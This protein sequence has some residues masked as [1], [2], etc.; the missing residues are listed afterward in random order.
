MTKT[1]QDNKQLLIRYARIIIAL[2]SILTVIVASYVLIE[3]KSVIVP[4]AIA[5]IFSFILKPLIEYLE[6]KHIPELLSILL[7][8]FI[9]FLIIYALG[10]LVNLNIRS[11]LAN[12]NQY[13]AK[14]DRFT[15][16]L[17]D[18]IN[19]AEDSS[20]ETVKNNRYQAITSIIQSSSIKSIVT[21][22]FG[23]ISVILSDT[24]LVLLYLL[25][26]LLGRNRLVQKLDIAFKRDTALVLKDLV[27]TVTSQINKYV[28]TKTW[29]SAVTAAL[30]SLILWLFGVEF[31]LIWG[32]LTFLLNFIPNIGSIFA[33][34]FPVIFSIIQFDSWITIIWI[35]LSLITVQFIIGNVLEPR[36]VGK[37]MGISPVVVLFSLMF[38]G[39]TWGII[40]MILAVPSAV[41]VK[42]IMDN[43]DTL[44]PF[45]VLISD[46]K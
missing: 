41:L 7:V 4:F 22:I 46:H 38:W 44:K 34:L 23:S 42:I 36:I 21:S 25:F 9:T 12:V 31:A 1:D 13:E 17:S 16:Q 8:I 27:N 32:M 39:F 30:V 28:V 15:E 29:I 45:G 14:Y 40:G 37:S 6:K 2:L 24:F 11:F 19:L 20:G 35:T 26:L 3:L 5:L 10:Q 43:I 33:T 18:I